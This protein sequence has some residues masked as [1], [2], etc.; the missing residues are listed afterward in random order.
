MKIYL[1][2]TELD[3]DKTLYSSLGDE[4]PIPE[5]D[6][7]EKLVSVAELKRNCEDAINSKAWDELIVTHFQQLKND[8]P[9]LWLVE[10]MNAQ[11]KVNSKNYLILYRLVKDLIQT[12]K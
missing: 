11:A 12:R 1:P 6:Q 4:F 3:A 2:N 5:K 10:L 9:E 8:Q 7:E